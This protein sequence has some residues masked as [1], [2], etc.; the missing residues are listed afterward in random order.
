MKTTSLVLVSVAL[1]T[2]LVAGNGKGNSN[3]SNSGVNSAQNMINIMPSYE[4]SDAQKADLVF[5]WEEE[6]LAKDIYLA[7]FELWGVSIFQNIASSEQQH[8]DSIAA[9]LTKYD[10]TYPS[11]K[12]SGSFENSELQALYDELIKKGSASLDDALAVGILIE[13][14]DIADLKA[15]IQVATEDVKVIY[16][17]LLNGSYNHLAAFQGVKDGSNVQVGTTN[18]NCNQVVMANVSGSG[19]HMLGTSYSGCSVSGLKAQGARLVFRYSNGKGGWID[20][21]TIKASEGF[22]IYK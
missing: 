1:A 2:A 5:M 12:S 18:N 19:W 13:E 3:G 20:E 10:I 11:S 14:A 9:L 8:Q 6:K 7:M 21:D 17:N 22:W 16:E 4:Q 15:R